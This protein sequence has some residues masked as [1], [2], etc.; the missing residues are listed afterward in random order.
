MVTKVTEIEE[1][2][3]STEKDLR[4][5]N[6]RKKAKKNII[7]YKNH[8]KIKYFLYIDSLTQQK[9]YNFIKSVW[10]GETLFSRNKSE[11][12]T[13]QTLNSI[14]NS[15]KNLTPKNIIKVINN[16]ETYIPMGMNDNYFKYLYN[17]TNNTDLI[18]NEEHL[19]F[20]FKAFIS[21]IFVDKSCKA[22][23]IFGD[24]SNSVYHYYDVYNIMTSITILGSKI[25]Y[26]FLLEKTNYK[27]PMFKNNYLGLK[28]KAIILKEKISQL[29]ATEKLNLFKSLYFKLLEVKND[30]YS[31]DFN[32][33]FSEITK[34][35]K[36]IIFV[37]KMFLYLLY[38]IN[39]HELT[40][41]FFKRVLF[42]K[43]SDIE[44]IVFLKFDNF[45][46]LNFDYK[47]LFSP[48]IQ[49]YFLESEDNN[50]KS[51][52]SDN[53][54]KLPKFNTYINSQYKKI[55]SLND[56]TIKNK[57][58]ISNNPFLISFFVSVI[59]DKIKNKELE[60]L[61]LTSL[62]VNYFKEYIV[63]NIDFVLISPKLKTDVFLV[64]SKLNKENQETL[65][66]DLINKHNNDVL[67]ISKILNLL[68]S[69]RDKLK[70]KESLV[71]VI[72]LYYQLL[73]LEKEC[74]WDFSKLGDLIGVYEGLVFINHE[75]SK[76]LFIV[77]EFKYCLTSLKNSKETYSLNLIKCL[78]EL[79]KILIK[80]PH[81]KDFYEKKLS[82][83]FGKLFKIK[84]VKHY[85]TNPTNQPISSFQEDLINMC[86]AKI[87]LRN[88]TILTETFVKIIVEEKISFNYL[89]KLSD[90]ELLLIEQSDKLKPLLG[91]YLLSKYSPMKEFADYFKE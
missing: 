29:K 14:S 2:Y 51:F 88:N 20:Y 81:L 80:Y 78:I 44:E 21:N 90:L 15:L 46:E 41:L 9:I 56:L 66:F 16:L 62:N 82:V 22:F 77:K 61:N 84:H 7:K 48:E 73:L 54:L 89:R 25:K 26:N 83:G 30:F 8:N 55:L 60:S 10:I 36:R 43:H 47:N 12:I 3:F 59:N 35:E 49:N 50:Y 65:F 63:K 38:Q 42:K 75:L 39:D 6:E 69:F 19:E 64:F 11:N 5:S 23:L 32:I 72:S 17:T 18:T 37:K 70:N 76:K 53:F 24:K 91:I 87:M 40:E 86:I 68:I 31:V 74:S 45:E 79:K 27:N 28:E 1:Y 34:E 58:K 52:L 57:Y 13:F 33:Y 67:L 71:D 85:Y 4:F